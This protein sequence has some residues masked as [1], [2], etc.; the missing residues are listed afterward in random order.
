[1]RLDLVLA[2]LF[3]FRLFPDICICFSPACW[4]FLHLF[5]L[6]SLLKWWWA[7]CVLQLIRINL[8]DQRMGGEKFVV[9]SACICIVEKQKWIHRQRKN[10]QKYFEISFTTVLML[11]VLN[12][13][14]DV[15]RLVRMYLP[16]G[17][18]SV[19][20]RKNVCE[21]Y[22]II[23]IITIIISA[24]VRPLFENNELS[25][26]EAIVI[27]LPYFFL[28]ERTLFYLNRKKVFFCSWVFFCF[29]SF[30]DRKW[31]ALFLNKILRAD[32]T[33]K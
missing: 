24:L 14:A 9:N 16:Q 11:L 32:L 8:N 1:M 25:L 7:V 26:V 17:H 10:K 19:C 22:N 33:V 6:V 21:P 3:F 13:T 5:L 27:L 28:F 20:F 30:V 15:K 4:I 12:T 23:V 29:F 2:I 18:H 31:S